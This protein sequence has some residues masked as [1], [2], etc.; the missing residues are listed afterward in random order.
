VNRAVGGRVAKAVAIVATLAASAPA[1]VGAVSPAAEALFQDGRRL[2]AEGKTAEACGRFAESY[3]IEASSGKL[4]N[5][6]LCHETEGKIATAWAE[7]R[8]TARLS[9]NEGR[10][11]RAATAVTKGAALE[12]RLPYLVVISAKPVPGLNVVSE[13]GA[14]DEGGLGVAVPIDPGVHQIKASAPGYRPWTASLEI[15]ETERHTLRVPELVAEPILKP[16]PGPAPADVS[17]L[18]TRPASSAGQASGRKLS[19]AAMILGVV[20]LAGLTSGALFAVEFES[21]NGEAK[22]ICANQP[23]TD[24]CSQ[25]SEHTM[26]QHD[27]LR[28][29]A[30]EITSF[31]LGGAALLTAAYLWWRSAPPAPEVAGLAV[32]TQPLVWRGG[33]GAS[34]EV[35]W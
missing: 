8:A 28:D 32:S 26:L 34:L 3:A 4:L 27:A 2:M 30:G 7:Y 21:S 5:L 18:S 15:K 19:N 33:F 12:S 9:R 14:L 25:A 17:L 10:E 22:L 35:P 29:L 13:V 23:T 31:G 6:A 24:A 11:D 1:T 20:G 16:P